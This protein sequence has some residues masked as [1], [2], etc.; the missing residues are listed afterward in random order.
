M[1]ILKHF[2][3]PK[4]RSALRKLLRLPPTHSPPNKILLR[5]WNK[6]I[7]TNIYRNIQTLAFKVH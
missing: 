4:Q 7:L 5:L 2:M 1:K 3:R 6:N